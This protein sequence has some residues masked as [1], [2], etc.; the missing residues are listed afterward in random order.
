MTGSFTNKKMDT[1]TPLKKNDDIEIE[2]DGLGYEGEGIAHLGGYTVFI[3]YALP[4]EKVRAHVIL[5]KPTFAVAKLTKVLRP[6]P[7]RAQPF[8]PV[9]CQCGGCSLQHMT[10][11]AQIRFKKDAVRE[12]F[13]KAA[14]L[15]VEPNETVSSPRQTFYRNK[16]SLPV[17]GAPA[18]LGFFAYGSH[19]VVSVDECPI[20]FEGN[21]EI[22]GAFRSFLH[23]NKIAGY[24]ETAKNGEV[25]HFVVRKI[26]GFYTV[27]VVANGEADK[28]GVQIKRRLQPFDAVL[29]ELYGENYAFYIN[30]NVSEG[31]RILGGQSELLGGN[32]TATCV[33]GL[34]VR[35]HP[36]AFFQVNDDVRQRLYAAVANEARAPFVADAY[37]GAGMLTALLAKHAENVTGVE[38]EPTAVQSA[39]E[40]VRANGITNAR[41]LCG[42]CALLLP[43]ALAKADTNAVVVLD[44]PRAGCARAVLDA[45]LA[46]APK[47]IVYVSCNP[48]TLA[49][50]VAALQNGGYTVSSLTPFDM[51]P[52]TANVETLCVLSRED[53]RG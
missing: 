12:A 7:E 30:Y 39:R 36:H 40:L 26:G 22:I 42:D 49:R 20:Q 6:S 31:N 41:F 18:T 21:G 1:A 46:A 17:R 29:H 11:D 47:K 43:Q 9:Y 32:E 13:Y 19:R 37:C 14:H 34:S 50:D 28:A 15:R 3:R 27:T 53:M 35:V 51:F 44:P 24:D 52:Q 8:C 38:L 5:A 25:R 4:H 33:D 45:V 2:I 48:A 23:E 16:M 10:Y